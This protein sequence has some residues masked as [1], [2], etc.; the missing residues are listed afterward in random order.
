MYKNLHFKIVVIF[1][2]FTMAIMSAVGAMMLYN[3]VSYYTDEFD[4]QMKR[5]FGDES[6]LYLELVSAFSSD[7]YFEKQNEIL[8]AY[9][10]TLGIDS[11]RDYYVLD[12][13]G[14]FVTGSDAKLGE[15]L[16]ITPNIISAI[17]GS[18]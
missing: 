9:S 3:T 7:N 13:N 12:N 6:D 1:V 10:G 5:S 15:E 8:K 4:T 17:N 11:H 18:L 14:N 16:E 2:V